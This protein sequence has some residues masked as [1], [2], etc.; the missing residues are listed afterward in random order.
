MRP[1]HVAV[2][3]F[4][5]RADRLGAEPGA[6]VLRR[7]AGRSRQRSGCPS[8]VS[9]ARAPARRRRPAPP[10]RRRRCRPLRRSRSRPTRPPAC[11]PAAPRA[12]PGRRSRVRTGTPPRRR[13]PAAPGARR[14]RSS[15]TNLRAIADAGF[16]R[17]RHAPIDAAPMS[18]PA[19]TSVG[20]GVRKRAN[21]RIERVHPLARRDLAQERHQRAGQP[22][23]RPERA[24]ARR[25][26]ELVEV[27]RVGDQPDARRPPR[28]RR[29]AAA[30]RPR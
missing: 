27:D 24:R 25:R 23:A 5:L 21:A 18:L 13:R 22:V 8:T 9:M 7:R 12:A 2:Q 3:R 10:A 29:A 16:A 28:P 19:T 30:A 14:L 26:L 4:E 20:P 1:H 11:R 6:D 17:R 15:P